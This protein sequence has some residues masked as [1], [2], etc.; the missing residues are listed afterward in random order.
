MQMMVEAESGQQDLDEA[1]ATV[2]KQFKMDEDWDSPH[3]K[4]LIEQMPA[5]FKSEC[6]EKPGYTSVHVFAGDD[7]VRVC[8]NAA[9]SSA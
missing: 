9:M 6:F 3:N 7:F 5:I 8:Q 1:M 2:T 4:A